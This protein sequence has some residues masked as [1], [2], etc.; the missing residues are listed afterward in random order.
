MQSGALPQPWPDIRIA[1]FSAT[2]LYAGLV[3]PGTY[4]FNVIIP[5]S[6]PD[7]DAA[8]TAGF[9]GVITQ[10]GLRITVKR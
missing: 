2:V 9:R 3:G 7:G 6:V 5:S 8:I 4:Q 1:G 10:S